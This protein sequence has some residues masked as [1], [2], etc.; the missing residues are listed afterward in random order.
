MFVW[1]MTNRDLRMRERIKD[2]KVWEGIGLLQKGK[3][4]NEQS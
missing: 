2:D 4:K 3:K 1:S